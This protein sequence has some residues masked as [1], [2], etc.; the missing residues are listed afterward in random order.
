MVLVSVR[1][2]DGA[3]PIA[4]VR[5]V[6]EVRQDQIDAEM[7]VARE[8]E[9]RVDDDDLAV[10]LEDGHVLADFADAAER[11]DAKSVRS[12]QRILRG[13]SCAQ[14]GCRGYAETG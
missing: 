1:E 8:S 7:L 4:A 6:G 2:D 11:N 14:I 5:Q 12:H 13:A 3:D 10:E 9:A